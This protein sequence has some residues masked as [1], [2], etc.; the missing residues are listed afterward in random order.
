MPSGASAVLVNLTATGTTAGSFLTV[1]PAGAAA[2]LASSL[3]WAAGAT[4]PNSVT[5]KLGPTGGISV[6]NAAGDVHV[7]ADTAGWYG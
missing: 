5:A 6:R 7:L 4:I 3:N 2:P 1:W